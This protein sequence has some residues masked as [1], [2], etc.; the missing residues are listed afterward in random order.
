[1]A[2]SNDF[3]CVQIHP[4]G[5]QRVHRQE[6]IFQRE[7]ARKPEQINGVFPCNGK[8]NTKIVSSLTGPNL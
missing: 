3:E 2:L 5:V 7:T 4:E 6:K 1:M 8:D